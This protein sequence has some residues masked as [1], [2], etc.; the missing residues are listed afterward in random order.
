M[1]NPARSPT[2]ELPGIYNTDVA[3]ANSQP[4]WEVSATST[5]GHVPNLEEEFVVRSNQE[6]WAQGDV[7]TLIPI[8]EDHSVQASRS[9]LQNLRHVV[10]N[11]G[12]DVERLHPEVFA[13]ASA[14][15]QPLPIAEAS[16]PSHQRIKAEDQVFPDKYILIPIPKYSPP[17]NPVQESRICLQNLRHVAKQHGYDV[18]SLHP[19]VFSDN[20]DMGNDVDMAKEKEIAQTNGDIN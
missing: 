8:A 9:C 4:P 19:E 16:Q 15:S 14:S 3:T 5:V 2:T 7:H 20:F 18:K 12:Y 6:H 10:K 17:A 11:Y 13:S 1:A